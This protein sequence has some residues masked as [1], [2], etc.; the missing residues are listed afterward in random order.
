VDLVDLVLT[1][2]VRKK[3]KKKRELQRGAV[4]IAKKSKKE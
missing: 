4:R 2:E 1:D 3:K